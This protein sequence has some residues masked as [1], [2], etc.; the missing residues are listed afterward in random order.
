MTVYRC[1]LLEKA[2][3]FDGFSTSLRER[4]H[5]LTRH[6][7]ISKS[8]RVFLQNLKS[9]LLI[10]EEIILLDFCENFSFIIQGEAQGF[11]WENSQCTAHPFVVYHEKSDDDDEITHKSFCFLSSNTKHNTSM[12]YTFIS[13][14]M[15]EITVYTHV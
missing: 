11:H 8:Q 13:A 5:K 4:I 2:E 14:L 3:D 7:F 9:N 12:V 1:I 15:P 6:H 10:N